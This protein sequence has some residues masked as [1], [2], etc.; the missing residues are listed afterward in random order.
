[1]QLDSS[2]LETFRARFEAKEPDPKNFVRRVTKFA[3]YLSVEDLVESR[4]QQGFAWEGIAEDFTAL[5]VTMPVST[6]KTCYRRARARRRGASARRQRPAPTTAARRRRPSAPHPAG[7]VVAVA[8]AVEAAPDTLETPPVAPE[9]PSPEPRAGAAAAVQ[10]ETTNEIA[11]VGSREEKAAGA[12]GDQA[13]VD[14]IP[15]STIA[16]RVPPASDPVSPAEAQ[17]QP[18]E[19]HPATA[20][21]A[22]GADRQR[23]DEVRSQASPRDARRLAFV[24]KPDG[25]L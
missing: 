11:D 8:A 13:L 24:P 14:E 12:A 20:T 5:G 23:L 16:G 22:I 15:S 3:F 19:M 10:S 9:M 6:L 4:R 1:M 7:D 25:D 17:P 21:S 2:Q 18:R